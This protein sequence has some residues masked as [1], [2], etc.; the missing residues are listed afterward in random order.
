MDTY[1]T[2]GQIE[3]VISKE[4]VKSY[5]KTFGIG[6]KAIKTYILED[7]I[8]V[9]Y[10]GS[11]LPFEKRLLE[12]DEGIHL[13]K[14]IRQTLHEI[15]TWHIAPIIEKITKQKIISSHSDISTKTGERVKIFILDANYEMVLKKKAK[16]TLKAPQSFRVAA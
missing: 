13:I 11:L 4:M 5:V 2:K 10:Q 8:I 12:K 14:N 3:D 9:R 15:S 7:M 16:T 6:P 1:F